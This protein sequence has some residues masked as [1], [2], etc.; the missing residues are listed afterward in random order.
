M[1]VQLYEPI[2]SLH[3]PPF[4][5]GLGAQLSISKAWIYKNTSLFKKVVHLR[6]AVF[7]FEFILKCF[8]EIGSILCFGKVKDV[9]VVNFIK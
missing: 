7:F 5:H 9:N 1:Q 8:T 3:A 2:P 4:W 6:K